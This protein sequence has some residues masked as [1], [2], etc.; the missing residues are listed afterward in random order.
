MGSQHDGVVAANR[1]PGVGRWWGNAR[2]RLGYPGEQRR[3]PGQGLRSGS[4]RVGCC[5]QVV[6]ATAPGSLSSQRTPGE[7]QFHADKGVRPSACAA[8]RG[9]PGA[10]V[11]PGKDLAVGGQLKE[12]PFSGAPSGRL[13]GK[14]EGFRSSSLL[15]SSRLLE[16]PPCLGRAGSQH[17]LVSSVSACLAAASV[18]AIR[19]SVLCAVRRLGWRSDAC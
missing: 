17:S 5:V 16:F 8:V 11:K 14:L 1:G 2:T 4:G 15:L 12:V 10:G 6:G 18:P 7:G 3:G 9:R 19:S 13:G